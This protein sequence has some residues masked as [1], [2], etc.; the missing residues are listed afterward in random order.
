MLAPPPDIDCLTFSEAEI[1]I[2]SPAPFPGRY[3]A[4]RTPYAR[5]VLNSFSDPMVREIVI[6]GASQI[7]KTTAILNMMAYGIA[8]RPSAMMMVSPKEGAAINFSKER[9]MPIIRASPMLR[10]CV[11]DSRD[12]SSGNTQRELHFPNGM[13]ALVGAES[14]TELASRPIRYLFC[15]EVGRYPVS[16]GDEGDPITLAIARTAEYWDSK[17]VLVS[18]PGNLG[19]CRIDEAFRNSDQR[20]YHVPCPKCGYLQRL[21]WDR[22]HW[23]RVE[24]SDGNVVEERPET[25]VYLCADENCGARWLDAERWDAIKHHAARWVASKPFRGSAGFQI[26]RLYSTEPKTLTELINRFIKSRGTPHM[27]KGFVNTV[28][29]ECWEEDAN[30]KIDI[31]DLVR[32][33]EVYPA[34]VPDGAVVLT[35]SLDVQRN[36]LELLVVAWGRGEECWAVWHEVIAKPPE[37]PA[38]WDEVDR[39]LLRRWKRRD[40]REFRIAATCIDSGDG[41]KQHLVLAYCASRHLV[42]DFKAVYAIKGAKEPAGASL[43]T[44]KGTPSRKKT[45]HMQYPV[46]SFKAK[47]TLHHRLRHVQRPGPWFIHFPRFEEGPDPFDQ[48]FFD[49]LMLGE[50]PKQGER[51]GKRGRIWVERK[52]VRNEALDLF[53]YCL[54]ALRSLEYL[55]EKHGGIILERLANKI[56]PVREDLVEDKSAPETRVVETSGAR[57][58]PVPV[59]AVAQKGLR[60]GARKPVFQFQTM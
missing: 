41:N 53:V 13:L 33:R 15:D 55:G 16:A 11:S 24:D 50:Y 4:W 27:Q 10:Q 45:G 54:A 14:P 36:R 28:L 18:S 29:G 48:E 25:A 12:R 46:Y 47:D 8:H 3:R 26:S 7:L 57:P 22:V 5:E 42:G 60:R 6:K 56:P 21:V 17:V 58:T 2:P 37:D 35:C 19:E 23:E 30:Q 31:N 51:D 49:Q 38:A 52:G 1:I 34:E 9:L 43:N 44:W 59:R 32:R 39:F 20:Y 40:G